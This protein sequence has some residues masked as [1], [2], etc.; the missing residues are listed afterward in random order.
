MTPFERAAADVEE[1]TRS[2]ADAAVSLV[3]EMTTEEKLSCLDGDMPFWPG[4]AD[5]MSGGYYSHPWPAAVN[6][7]LGIPGLQFADGPRGCVI[8]A[9]TTFP[10]AMARG[11]SFDPE[12]E[13][14]VGEAIG[15]ELRASGATF[16]GAVCM[17][18]LRHPAW[19]RAQETYGEDPLHVGA[20]A[21]ALTLGLQ[22]HVMACM[23]HFALNSMENARFT[24]D[25]T[26]DERA[27]HEVY[28]PHFKRVADAGVASVMSAYN[29]VNGSW[30]GDSTE[31][32]TDILRNEWG[33]DG[34]VITDFLAGLRDPIG[35]I[36]AGC[37]IEM[38]F[39][40]QRAVV[41][42]DAVGNG[43]LDMAVVDQRA[44]EILATFLR[45]AAIFTS[46]PDPSVV[47]GPAHRALARE[48][49]IDSTVLLRNDGLL[50]LDRST[51]SRV[52]VIGELAA[53]A[54]LGDAGS[55]NVLHTPAPV[56]LLAG[57]EQALDG[58]NVTHGDD[59]TVAA[60]ADL[61]IVVVGYTK[62]DE[63]EYVGEG[64]TEV[65][66]T[67]MP[68]MDH[69]VVGTD[70]PAVLAAIEAAVGGEGVA[71]PA[72]Q[73]A[74]GGDRDSLRLRPEHEALIDATCETGTPTV[75]VVV[76]GSAVVMPWLD[77][78][79]ATMMLWYAGS[80]GGHALADVLLGAEPGGRLPFAVPHD[81]SD[82][83]PFDK[84]ATEATYE[85]LHGQWWLDAND[86]PAHL[87]FGSGLSY[88]SIEIE[89]A[90]RTDT[91][92]TAV[93]ANT[94][95]RA[96]STVLYVFGSVP[97]SAHQRPRQR[98]VGLQKVRVPAGGRVETTVALD[99]TQLDI[100]SDGG[101]ITEDLPIEL[102][103]GTDAAALHPVR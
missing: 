42:A 4:I 88:A 22:E 30:C 37:N 5:M 44:T 1:G 19:G 17:N 31:L 56:T 98:L 96:G 101:W 32:L 54:N 85:L 91:D 2:A 70:D 52:A 21:E 72:G 103:I 64:L 95:D 62:D 94:S 25:V 97:G 86:T 83:V 63:G 49:A 57:I 41:V 78:P 93:V 35:S 87:P 12:L 36:V 26:V 80:D 33:W 45:F 60:D 65:L 13:R 15:A 74:L 48:A 40:Q 50:P 34:F 43:E 51:L 39:A 58:V 23:K 99:L 6:E 53:R 10:V 84:T 102:A 82:L 55:S 100:R 38:P 76:A 11:A 79:A 71:S 90:R 24:V 81:E 29:S 27:L 7:R 68:P 77:Q 3:A 46:S 9:A 59:P 92:V 20:M 14:R 89:S 73:V 18:L 67:L 16:T 47:A 66:G 69:P 8:S 75:V 28:L 61:A